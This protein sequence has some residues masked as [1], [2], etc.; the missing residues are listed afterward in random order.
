[1]LLMLCC[2]V[3]CFLSELLMPVSFLFDVFD[4]FEFMVFEVPT[5][6][7]FLRRLTH[8]DSFL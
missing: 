8:R 3:V 7:V 4:L 2:P 1:M 6:G 5:L